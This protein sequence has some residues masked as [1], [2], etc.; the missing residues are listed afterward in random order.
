MRQASC[1]FWGP[2]QMVP[3]DSCPAGSWMHR[4]CG[5]EALS[6]GCQQDLGIWDVDWMYTFMFFKTP[7]CSLLWSCDFFFLQWN[8]PSFSL[9][10][11]STSLRYLEFQIQITPSLWEPNHSIK[12]ML[13][14]FTYKSCPSLLQKL[15]ILQSE[16]SM[17]SLISLN[18]MCN[19]SGSVTVILWNLVIY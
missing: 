9:Y 19:Y 1:V 16:S 10:M 13:Y 2:L 6:P 14:N 4:L 8:G 15:Q 5:C 11:Q 18:E 7:L 17:Q 3:L 12:R